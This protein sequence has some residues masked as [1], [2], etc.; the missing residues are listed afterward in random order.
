M[1]AILGDR[2][3]EYTPEEWAIV[4]GSSDFFGLNTYTS[5]LVR[6]CRYI[7]CFEAICWVEAKN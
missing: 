3:P 2:L 6:E 7:S 5:N 1:K 4:K